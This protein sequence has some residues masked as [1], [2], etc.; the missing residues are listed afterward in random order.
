MAITNQ[1]VIR[2]QLATIKEHLVIWDQLIFRE[3]LVT[4]TAVGYLGT[5]RHQGTAVVI[6]EQLN[7]LRERDAEKVFNM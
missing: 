7:I 4:Q 5:A 6:R 3:Q 2:E 1:Q